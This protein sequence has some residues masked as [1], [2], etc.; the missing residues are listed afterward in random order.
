[1]TYHS[2]NTTF[3]ALADPTR[4]AMLVRLMKGPATVKDLARPFDMTL[5][6][7]LQHLK[8]LESSGL[9]RT[10]KQG[11][12]RTCHAE[13]AALAPA[14]DWI[15]EQRAIW[16]SRLDRLEAYLDTP[17]AAPRQD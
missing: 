8:K 3:A 10:E 16:A 7:T 9:I 6:T 12:T 14:Q 11:R 15:A 13:P 1:M 5:P 17:D 2:L 4:R